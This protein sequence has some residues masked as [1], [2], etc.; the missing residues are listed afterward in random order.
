MTNDGEPGRRGLRMG[1]QRLQRV[2]RVLEEVVVIRGAQKRRIVVRMIE[3]AASLVVAEHGESLTAEVASEPLV[4][5]LDTAHPVSTAKRPVRVCQTRTGDQQ[6][7]RIR[8]VTLARVGQVTLERETV[9]G[10][11]RE[12]LFGDGAG[13]G[14]GH[15]HRES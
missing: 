12:N 9:V 4:V 6:N 10:L 11:E 5:L 3:R 1:D 2:A 13:S 8:P 15:S 7:A 14:S